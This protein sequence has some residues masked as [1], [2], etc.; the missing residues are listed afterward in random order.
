MEKTPNKSKYT[1]DYNSH[2]ESLLDE[3]LN[4]I[5][6]EAQQAICAKHLK[7]L[8]LGGGYGRGE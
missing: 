4:Q 1:F 8:V 5:A 6:H 2:I 7:Y 3:S